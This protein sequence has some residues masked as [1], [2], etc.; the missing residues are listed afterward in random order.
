[1]VKNYSIYLNKESK[2]VIA[3]LNKI[4]NNKIAN[5]NILCE[6]SIIALKNKKKIIFFGNGG[7]AA[8]AQHLATELVVRFKKNRK[9]ISAIALTTDTSILTAISNDFSFKK[10]FSRQIEA[11]GMPGDIVIAITTSGNSQNL[12]E[13][14]KMANKMNMETFCF[15][16]NR[17]GK[18]KKETKYPILVDSNE[19][20][21]TQTVEIMIGQCFCEA[22]EDSILNKEF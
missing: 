20:S 13:A 10:I 11:I 16:G 6:K 17:G 21:T 2:N 4:K 8:D 7:S 12:I 18:I 5:F 9:P 14:I 1:M 22:I 3:L 15:S 19:T